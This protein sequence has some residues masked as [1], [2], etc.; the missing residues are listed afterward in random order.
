MAN[1]IA[2][3]IA[4]NVTDSFTGSTYPLDEGHWYG[5]KNEILHT[6]RDY[7]ESA[8]LSP[9]VDESTFDGFN[10]YNGVPEDSFTVHMV[11][12]N[13]F[14]S[15]LATTALTPKLREIAEF[16]GQDAV[17]LSVGNSQLIQSTVTP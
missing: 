10:Y 17:A 7:V 12:S 16:Y 1:F 8:Y 3:T 5:F 14:Y 6:L 11:V 2:V 13:H 4:R 9:V 15:S